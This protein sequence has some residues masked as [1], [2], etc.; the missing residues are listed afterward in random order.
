MKSGLTQEGFRTELRKILVPTDVSPNAQRAL[1]WAAFLAATYKSE[2]VLLHVVP[3]AS[4]MWAPD[5][6]A[7]RRIEKELAQLWTGTEEQLKEVA[8]TLR[9]QVGEVLPLAIRGQPFMEICE[10]AKGHAADLIVMGTHGRTG[11][12]HV[13]LGSVAERVVRHAPCPVLTV[14]KAD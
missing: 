4:A 8:S 1:E 12:D 5:V 14:R 2:I 3:P 11:L 7:E 10:V 13:L 9:Q 6:E